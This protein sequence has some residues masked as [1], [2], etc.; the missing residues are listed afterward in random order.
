LEYGL[1]MASVYQLTSVKQTVEST[2]QTHFSFSIVDAVGKHLVVFSYANIIDAQRC[3]LEMM[4][5]IE[6]ASI[7][8]PLLLH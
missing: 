7:I 8:E 3:R 5:S 4:D 6:T 1:E 2:G